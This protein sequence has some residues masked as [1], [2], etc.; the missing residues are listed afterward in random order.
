MNKVTLKQYLSQGYE[1]AMYT[2]C[3]WISERY[4]CSHISTIHN[5]SALTMG[6]IAQWVLDQLPKQ[7]GG[8]DTI[9]TCE[10]VK[11]KLWH[12]NG[13][14]MAT[15]GYINE[16]MDVEPVVEALVPEHILQLEL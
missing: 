3:V 8:K 12:K 2:S 7:T 15:I 14:T 13:A 1:L 5:L 6:T 16:H 4:T 11:A 10:S 9:G